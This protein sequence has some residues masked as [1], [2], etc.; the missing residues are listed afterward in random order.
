MKQEK[1]DKR[2]AKRTT[3]G[4]APAPARSGP[5]VTASPG[6]SGKIDWRALLTDW[7]VALVLVLVLVSAIVIYPHFEDGKLETNLQFGLDLNE[8]AWLQLDL[9]SEVV[10]F[11]TTEKVEDFVSNLSTALDT[12]VQL[13]GPDQIEIRKSLTDEE[14]RAAVEA[15]WRHGGLDPAGRLE[16][17]RRGHQADPG[18]QDQQPRDAGREGQHALGPDGD[19]A[20]H[21]DRDGRRRYEHGPGDRGQ[22]GQV[23]DPDRD[24]RQRLRARPLRRPDHLGRAAGAGTAGL[25]QLGRRV[26]PLRGGRDRTPRGRDPVR[27]RE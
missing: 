15:G 2:A 8:G 11:Q 7:R 10:T 9:Q 19:H 18:E 25:E 21:P 1:K 17:D 20:V 4:P 5:A 6:G 22:A 12:D 13:V 23:R 16:D 27:G 26:H 3:D 14:I 24:D